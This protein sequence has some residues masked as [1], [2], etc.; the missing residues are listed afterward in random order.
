MYLS[1]DEL[2]KF[3][4]RCISIYA[5]WK[6]VKISTHPV[7]IIAVVMVIPVGSEGAKG[8]SVVSFS[9][10]L[11]KDSLQMHLSSD[12]DK[13][14]M[15]CNH[16]LTVHECQWFVVNPQSLAHFIIIMAK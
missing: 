11:Q 15:T 14:E 5:H 12:L 16:E 13:N 8:G 3:M 9:A 7:V 1:L 4:S 10:G 6:H 2:K